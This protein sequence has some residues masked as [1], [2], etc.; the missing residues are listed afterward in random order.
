MVGGTAYV[1]LGTVGY[2]IPDEITRTLV[3]PAAGER[4]GLTKTAAMFHVNPHRWQRHARLTGESTVAGERVQE[5]EAG[6]RPER[7][8]LDLARLTRFL[9]R[10]GVTQALG[11]P[12]E[13]G[14]EFRAALARS[15]TRASG[16]VWMG[17]EDH[18]LRKARLEGSGV[19]ARRDRKLLF[20]ATSAS[21][22]ANVSVT[23]VGVAQE[24]GA[25]KQ[26]DSY[27]SLQLA[28]SALGEAVRRDSRAAGR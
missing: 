9:S 15:V 20:G 19:V 18:V 13:L 22:E 7:A 14:P 12:T 21:L 17:R 24:I 23:D 2:R 5:I 11:L 3:A 26:L 8:L 16:K 1:K 10:L 27:S 6:I 28:L 4:N 25:P